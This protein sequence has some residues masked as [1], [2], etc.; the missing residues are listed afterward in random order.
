MLGASGGV[1]L[2][3]VE[4]G[5]LMGAEVIAVARGA[6]KL[7]V[8]KG[9]GADHLVNSETDDIREIVKG[10]GGADV[11]YDPIGGDQFKAAMRAC[12][13]E[14]RLIP[15]GFASGEVPQIPA[16][17]LLVKNLTVIG[18]YWGG[19]MRVNPKVL[20]D[21]FEVLIQ[22][23]TQGKL[24]PHV[25]HVLPLEQANEALELLRTRKATGKVVVRIDD[26]E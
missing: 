1:G 8:A 21:S 14:A 26:E 2:T 4:L 12:R 11:V 22:W 13:P 15:L 9:A 25:S 17:H 23:Y 24:K 6:E 10:L 3:A 18:F 5:K 19:Y 7:A 20:T 16:N